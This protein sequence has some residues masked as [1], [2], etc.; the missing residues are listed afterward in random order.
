MLVEH[1]LKANEVRV[2][3]CYHNDHTMV[4]YILDDYDLHREMA[5]ECYRLRLEEVSKEARFIAKGQ[6]VFASF[7]GSWY[8]DIARSMWESINTDKL[9]TVAGVPL[10]QHLATMGITDRGA[11]SGGRGSA[12]PD[13][14][15][16]HIQEVERQFWQER[17]PVYDKWRDD[18]WEQYCQRGWF[19]M[20]TGFVV[21]GVYK[22][23]EVINSPVQGAA[24]HCLL[25]GLIRIVREL[26]KKKMR[27]VVVGQIHDSIIAD[28]HESELEDY[29]AMVQRVMVHDI[30]KAWPW[31]IVPLG[32]EA[33]VCAEN[34]WEKR[35]VELPK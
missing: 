27:S 19:R 7:Y 32:L 33:S 8:Q 4:Q 5:G 2:A 13:T 17:F 11:C 6:F 22:R 20:L 15:E 12:L 18:W 3:A 28:V 9:K 16:D 10:D 25:W 26:R 34:W 24:F 31:L 29:L 14:F 30:R 35:E 21:Q 1:D 23:T